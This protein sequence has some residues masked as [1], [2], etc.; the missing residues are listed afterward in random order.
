M[1]KRESEDGVLELGLFLILSVRW[2]QGGDKGVMEQ[3]RSHPEVTPF[4]LF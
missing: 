1:E 4:N 2:R 3:G